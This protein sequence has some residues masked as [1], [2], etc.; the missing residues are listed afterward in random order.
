M[1]H[2]AS[3]KKNR[4]FH[5]FII[6][7]LKFWLHRFY[8]QNSAECTILRP[9]ELEK[10]DPPLPLLV[11]RG[12]A[13]MWYTLSYNCHIHVYGKGFSQNG[14]LQRHIRTHTG[15][16]AYK[17]DVHMYVI[18]DLVWIITYRHTLEY[19]HVQVTGD[20]PYK[21]HICGKEF[22]VSGNLQTHYKN[23]YWW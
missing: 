11:S 10:K 15:D 18:K 14:N 20:T 7:Y 9:S 23:T 2:F 12:L 17:C 5:G 1:H 21:C 4:F 22:S 8:I 3:W 19:I 6:L 13:C 16:K